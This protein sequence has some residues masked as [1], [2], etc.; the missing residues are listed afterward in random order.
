MKARPLV[1]PTA[2]EVRGLRRRRR[3]R[4]RSR[5]CSCCSRSWLRAAVAAGTALLLPSPADCR[6]STWGSVMEDARAG[7]RGMEGRARA[8][9]G[10][11]AWDVVEAI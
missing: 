2:D 8:V 11:A 3:V 1:M 6:F 5:R 7:V 9:V 4:A 10:A